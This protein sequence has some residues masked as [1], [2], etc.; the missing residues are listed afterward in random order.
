M[1]VELLKLGWGKLA[2]LFEPSPEPS[3]EELSRNFQLQFGVRPGDPGANEIVGRQ[4]QVLSL[5]ARNSAILDTG[6]GFNTSVAP[7]VQAF[8]RS[9]ALAGHFGFEVN[10]EGDTK[11][12]P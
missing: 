5:V 8:I 10:P 7:S 9:S 1:V 2:V 6:I 12:Q 4:L 3:E 11:P